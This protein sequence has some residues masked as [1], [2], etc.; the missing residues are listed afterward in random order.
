M[1]LQDLEHTSTSRW[2]VFSSTMETIK[3]DNDDPSSDTFLDVVSWRFHEWFLLSQ[4]NSPLSAYPHFDCG[5]H[6]ARMTMKMV[7]LVFFLTPLKVILA[8]CQ[9]WRSEMIRLDNQQQLTL[10][11]FP[12]WIDGFLPCRSCKDYQFRRIIKRDV[13]FFSSSFPMVPNQQRMNGI[14]GFMKVLK[15][16]MGQLRGQDN[17]IDMLTGISI[18]LSRWL[19]EMDMLLGINSPWLTS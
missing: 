5:W 17:N 16:S 14:N 11:G 19:A 6:H 2:C 15:T 12:I 13:Q 4:E 9:S 7:A 1:P 18:V 8:V 10:S 3:N